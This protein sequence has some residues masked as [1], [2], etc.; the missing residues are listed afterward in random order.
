[1]VGS[2]KGAKARASMAKDNDDG[3]VAKASDDTSERS[4]HLYNCGNL[5]SSPVSRL[6]RFSLSAACR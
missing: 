2:V 3:E 5:G 4:P 6:S 1:M